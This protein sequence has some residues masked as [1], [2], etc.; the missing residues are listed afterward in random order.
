MRLPAFERRNARR[1]RTPRIATIVLP[2]GKRPR[3]CLVTDMSAEGVRV[4]PTGFEIPDEFVLRFSVEGEINEARYKVVWRLG[5]DV[6]AKLVGKTSP[7]AS[8]D[9]QMQKAI[10]SQS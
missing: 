4:N 2:N 10:V 1:M 3:H 7:Q 9:L 5:N 6:G 8:E